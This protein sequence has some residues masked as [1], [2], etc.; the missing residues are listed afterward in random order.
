MDTDSRD[1]VFLVSYT[2]DIVYI[3]MNTLTQK[4]RYFKGIFS[5]NSSN[6]EDRMF[7]FAAS[8]DAIMMYKRYM[9]TG[10]LMLEMH[11]NSDFMSLADRLGTISLDSDVYQLLVVIPLETELDMQI[12]CN[13][14]I[15]TSRIEVLAFTIEIMGLALHLWDDVV[16]E[17]TKDEALF[18]TVF[19][20][21][22]KGSFATAMRRMKDDPMY[23]RVLKCMIRY[24]KGI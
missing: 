20:D 13:E 3:D 16:P 14:D 18:A 10:I 17:F 9:E 22:L 6:R 15:P 19:L 12:L 1:M 8:T 4:T 2:G 21:V 24:V 11:A 23:I 5:V 7:T